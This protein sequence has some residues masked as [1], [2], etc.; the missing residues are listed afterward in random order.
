MQPLEVFKTVRKKQLV[1]FVSRKGTHRA[2]AGLDL[3]DHVCEWLYH[4]FDDTSTRLESKMT[5]KIESERNLKNVGTTHLNS[6]MW[7]R[8]CGRRIMFHWIAEEFVQ[9]R[10]IAF[11]RLKGILS[12]ESSPES[13]PDYDAILDATKNPIEESS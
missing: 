13:S 6:N 9:A 5:F 10:R 4:R 12:I 8:T 7:R 1:V 3:V 2:V 11:E